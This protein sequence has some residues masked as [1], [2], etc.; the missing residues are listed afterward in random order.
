MNFGMIQAVIK[1]F[2]KDQQSRELRRF[3]TCPAVYLYDVLKYGHYC[4]MRNKKLINRRNDIKQEWQFCSSL[5]S[6]WKRKGQ[7]KEKKS[8]QHGVF[9]E[10]HPAKYYP[11][12]TGLKFVERTDRVAVLVV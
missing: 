2:Q 6:P 3:R 10:G 11:R 8:S 9:V 5:I 12:R 7:K 4:E 1:C